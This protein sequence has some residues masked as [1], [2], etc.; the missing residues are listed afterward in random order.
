M[1]KAKAAVSDFMSKSGHHD[2]TVHENVAPAVTHEVINPQRE[3]RVTTAI[4][5]EVHQDHHH[6][7]VQ[8]VK[9]REILPEEH[10]HNLAGVEHR[11]FDHGNASNVKERLQTEAAQFTSKREVAPTIETKTLDPTVAGEH[12]HHHVHETIQPVVQKETIQPSVVHTTVPIHEVHNNAAQ[13]HSASALPA[14]SMADFKKAG[15]VLEGRGERY[16][17]FEGEPRSIGGSLKKEFGL[18][19]EGSH[20]SNG[21]LHSKSDSLTGAN[22]DGLNG[23][24]AKPSMMDKLNPKKDADMDGKVG[25]MD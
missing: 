25:I 6:T 8:P 13:H 22:G 19:H 17:A 10:T 21:L 16:D 23:A 15:G 18:G 3:E 14:V 7:S 20:D 5:R 12:V 24:H 11:N 4:D 1:Q 2:T 9:D